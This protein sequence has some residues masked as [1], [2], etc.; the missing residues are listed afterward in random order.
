M[1]IARLKIEKFLL[2]YVL[3]NQMIN[4]PERDR[5]VYDLFCNE[6]TTSFDEAYFLLKEFSLP[7]FT[8]KYNEYPKHDKRQNIH[9]YFKLMEARLEWADGNEN[10]A[11]KKYL[12]LEKTLVDTTQEKLFRAR[13]FEGMAKYYEDDGNE[14]KLSVYANAL[15]EEYPQLLPFSGI[16]PGMRLNATGLND[17]ATKRVISELKDC[18]IDWEKEAGH[19]VANINFSKKNNRYEVIINVA[20]ASGKPVVSK[21]RIVFKDTDK[22]VGKEIAMRLFGKGGALTYENNF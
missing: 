13:L 1:K 15:L 11:R 20:S 6:S 16:T 12:E 22:G 9:R 2:E 18:D 21:Q 8:K 4:N 17:K 14:N 5:S 7:Y 19:P 10:T 3:V